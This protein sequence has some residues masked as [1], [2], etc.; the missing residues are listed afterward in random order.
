MCC[1]SVF[2]LIVFVI[3]RTTLGSIFYVMLSLVSFP[4]IAGMSAKIICSA[5]NSRLTLLGVETCPPSLYTPISHNIKTDCLLT[6][7]SLS[8]SDS[9]SDRSRQGPSERTLWFMASGCW[10][11]WIWLVGLLLR[12]WFH[13]IP[14]FL[15]WI[16]TCRL[17]RSGQ[18]L[19]FFVMFLK[20]FLN[21]I[22]AH[23]PTKGGGW[24]FSS[25]PWVALPWGGVLGLQ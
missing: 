1:I 21:S 9:N 14:W 19:G 13:H 23:C 5:P 7:W 3:W 10:I 11:L 20:L 25:L 17:C 8:C 15:N 2:R 24:V 22:W 12:S 18:Y 4:S 16:R 6:D